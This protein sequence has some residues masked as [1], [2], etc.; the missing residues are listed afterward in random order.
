MA[1]AQEGPMLIDRRTLLQAGTGA[2]VTLL[3][4]AC[5]GGGGGPPLGAACSATISANHG[6]TLTIPAA[7]LD[8]TQARS[9]SIEGAAGHAHSVSFTA[10]QLA[11][12]KAGQPVTVTSSITFDHSHLV[13]PMCG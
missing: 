8:A 12:I 6:H 7:D 2:T 9:Y 11:Q 4:Q 13:T 10:A 1:P 5:G 3:L